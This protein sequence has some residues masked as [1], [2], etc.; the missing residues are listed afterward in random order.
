MIRSFRVVLILVTGVAIVTLAL[1]FGP[2]AGVTP[3]AHAD[4]GDPV[5]GAVGDMACGSSDRSFNNNQGKPLACAEQRTSD[6]MLADP[7]ITSV[8]GLGDYQYDCGDTADYAVSYDPSWGRMDSRM[9]PVA[10]NHE[11]KT[12]NDVFGHPCPTTNKTA[13]NFFT[14]FGASSHPETGGH[15]S[16]DL[17]TWHLIGLNG[18]CTASGVG[19]CTD[20]SAQTTWLKADLAST[21]QPCILAFWHQPLY[22]GLANNAGWNRVYRPWWNALQAAGADVVL[23]G[24]IHNYQRYPALDDNGV[25]TP[26]GITEYVAGT[27]GEKQVLTSAAAAVAPL[28][29]AKS[30][31]YLRMTLLP[32]G[33]TADFVDT[34]GTVLDSS[35]GVCHV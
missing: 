23:N 14:H 26:A 25:Q 17:G 8:L 29:W 20:T 19:G 24:H 10:G 4:I 16:F 22:T 27:G 15:F 18:N 35:S 33:W 6:A 32:A 3:Q 21:L 31:G 9:N 2:F 13:T 7:T 28:A 30:F 11:Y 1:S 5:I 12:G 34:T